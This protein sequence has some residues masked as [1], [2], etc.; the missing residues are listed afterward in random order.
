MLARNKCLWFEQ[1]DRIDALFVNA[2]IAE[3][4]PLGSI[5]ESQFDKISIS[6]LLS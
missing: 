3:V 2:G 6:M 5:T 1:E 4:A